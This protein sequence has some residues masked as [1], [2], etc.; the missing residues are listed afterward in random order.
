MFREGASSS[1]GPIR[2]GSSS[3]RGSSREYLVL[4]NLTVTLQ[5]IQ[6]GKARGKSQPNQQVQSLELDSVDLKDLV[7]LTIVLR[8]LINM[9]GE[10]LMKLN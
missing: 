5:Q 9:L 8:C 3:S 6:R 10:M 7:F 4:D 1:N 2:E